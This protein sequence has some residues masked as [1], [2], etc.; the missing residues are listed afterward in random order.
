MWIGRR[1]YI[2]RTDVWKVV[3]FLLAFLIFLFA[4]ILLVNSDMKP[5]ETYTLDAVY[6][7]YRIQNKKG[8]YGSRK[9]YISVIDSNG[10]HIE[11]MIPGVY[12][13]AFDEKEFKENAK[14]G[15]SIELTLEDD[16]PIMAVEVNGHTYMSLEETIKKRDNNTTLGYWVFGLFCI[17]SLIGIFWFVRPK[18]GYPKRRRP[19]KQK[20]ED[21]K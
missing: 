12:I 10:Q 7:S 13:W 3:A 20:T 21:K 11:H 16:G 18:R 2:E 14:A 1:L 6:D 9:F 15:D 5:L 17:S 4:I 19:K 8:R